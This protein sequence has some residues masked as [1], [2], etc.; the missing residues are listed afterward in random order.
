[1]QNIPWDV[2]LEIIKWGLGLVSLAVSGFIGFL[3]RR[4]AATIKRISATETRV[5]QLYDRMRTLER[6]SASATSVLRALRQ[7]LLNKMEG[8][9]NTVDQRMDE[10]ESEQS[11]IRTKIAIETAVRAAVEAAKET[12]K[13]T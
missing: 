4:G 6:E 9:N 13:G 8:I 12:R 7:E 5:Q 10:L 11:E 2:W 1:M 3:W